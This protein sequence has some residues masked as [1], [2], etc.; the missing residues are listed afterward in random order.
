MRHLVA[1][2]LACAA[3]G[4]A[5]AG[6][7]AGTAPAGKAAAPPTPEYVIKNTPSGDA[8]LARLKSLVGS[9]TEIFQY[10][11]AAS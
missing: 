4:S 8:A 7:S 2:G 6:S 1:F 10:Q 5:L 9:W 3:F 11:R